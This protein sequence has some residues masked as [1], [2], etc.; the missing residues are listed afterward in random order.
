MNKYLN[1]EVKYYGYPQS[2]YEK[3]WKH[4]IHWVAI[5]SSFL[6]MPMV[7][8]FIMISCKDE[9]TSP[10][11]KPV[12]KNITDFKGFELELNTWSPDQFMSWSTRGGELIVYFQSGRYSQNKSNKAFEV[13]DDGIG[14]LR[15][16]KG[17]WHDQSR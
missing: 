14:L 13:D 12:I 1:E 2:Y 16:L 11:D 3:R 7:I 4:I 15:F 6:F 9:P 17:F 8:L 5:W 10:F